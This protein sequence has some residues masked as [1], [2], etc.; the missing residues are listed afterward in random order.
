MDVTIFLDE[1][2]FFFFFFL[3]EDKY[4]LD[5]MTFESKEYMIQ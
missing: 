4:L 3:E 1:I 5:G 2:F